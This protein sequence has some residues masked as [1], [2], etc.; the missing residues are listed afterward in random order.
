[1][2]KLS[3]IEEVKN[4]DSKRQSIL[5]YKHKVNR[6]VEEMKKVKK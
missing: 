5:I 6:P 1:M 3:A 4:I 2:K